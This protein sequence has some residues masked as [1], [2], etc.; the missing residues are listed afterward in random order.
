MFKMI[1]Q[2]HGRQEVTE[3]DTIDEARK[4]LVDIAVASNCRVEGDNA[5]GVFIALTR[6]GRDNPLVD[7]TYGAYRITEEPAE[8]VDQAL[9]AATARYM[10][11]ENLDADTVQMIRNSDRDGRDLLAA[12]V[13]EW[14]KLH[15]ELADR[16]RHA[17]AAAANGWQRFDYA[18]VPSQ[19]RY[20]RD[21]GELAIVE[22]DDERAA[23]SAEL[24][25]HGVCDAA[26]M[27]CCPEDDLGDV[28]GWL[29][30]APVPL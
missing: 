1:V 21:G 19:V 23:R 26:L 13:A 4:R 28:D 24:Y 14:L 25:V 20:A 2:L 5:T 12:I 16:D 7:W 29:V 6:E 18:L 17:V 11:D 3:H 9:A 8:G 30:A 10:I 27:R 15:P 22:Y